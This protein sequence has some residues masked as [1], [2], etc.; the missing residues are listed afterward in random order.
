M[1]VKINIGFGSYLTPLDANEKSEIDDAFTERCVMCREPLDEYNKS[2][3]H[4]FPKWLQNM[5]N[6]QNQKI[7]LPNN[8]TTLYRQFL[9]PCCK[10]C[11]NGVMS[12]WEKTIEAAI[13]K[14][15][16]LVK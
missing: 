15:H 16:T 11:N 9:V 2:D 7:T 3:E 14:G 12:A 6:L 1:S 13:S 10:E 4:I 8:S 5:F